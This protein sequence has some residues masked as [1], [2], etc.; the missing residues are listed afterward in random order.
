[1][2]DTE[3]ISSASFLSLP[4]ARVSIRGN[5]LD[6][7]EVA[8]CAD[9]RGRMPDIFHA[10]RVHVHAARVGSVITPSLMDGRRRPRIRNTGVRLVRV[11]LGDKRHFLGQG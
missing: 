8:A 5:N 7:W 10:G 3:S 9:R 11:R 1:M 4:S 6:V 2:D